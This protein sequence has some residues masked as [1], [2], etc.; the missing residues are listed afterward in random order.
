[1]VLIRKSGLFKDL[2]ALQ[3]EMNRLFN[4]AFSRFRLP[5][6]GPMAVSW[7]PAVDIYETEDKIVVKAE[8]PGVD[9]KD[10]SIEIRDNTLILKGEKKAEKTVKEENYYRL[11]RSYGSFQRTFSLPVNIQQDKITA[12]YK[13]GV[14]EILLPKVEEAKPR[15]IKIDVE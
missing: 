12:K 14:L 6:E 11:E 1:M 13:D 9:R 7:S 3:E 8:L 2:M 5:E 4:E 10:V 15:Q